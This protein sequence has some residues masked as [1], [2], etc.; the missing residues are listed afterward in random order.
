[1][2]LVVFVV[3]DRMRLTDH[4]TLEELTFSEFAIRRGIDNRPPDAV[5]PRLRMLAEGLERVRALLGVPMRISSGYR[6]WSLNHAIG[7]AKNSA[8]VTG[9]AADFTA[10]TFGTPMQVALAIADSGIEFDQVIH[11]GR[12]VHVS[13]APAMRRMDLTAT[14]VNGRPHYT[15]GIL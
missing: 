9:F 14:F 13:F 11:E 2:A 6:C 3:G 4:F 1:M 5:L 8:H 7:G 15:P 10:P 12:W